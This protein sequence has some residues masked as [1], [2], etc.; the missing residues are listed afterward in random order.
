MALCS[1]ADSGGTEA[2]VV[3][4]IGGTTSPAGYLFAPGGSSE[5]K[6]ACYLPGDEAKFSISWSDNPY[7]GWQWSY[8]Y[9]GPPWSDS[10]STIEAGSANPVAGENWPS[11]YFPGTSSSLP[12]PYDYYT[13]F[14]NSTTYYYAYFRQIVYSG[15]SNGDMP[16]MSIRTT[17]DYY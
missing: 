12:A 14:L 2:N 7:S 15:E 8:S 4:A 16:I 17:G 10:L 1:P 11:L 6:Y 9:Y 5:F 13:G 3:D